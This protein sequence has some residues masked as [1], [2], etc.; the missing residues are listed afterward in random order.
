MKQNKIMKRSEVPEEFTWKLSDIFE[1]DEAWLEA[2]EE[3]KAYPK[4]YA[5]LQGKLGESAANLLKYFKLE[6]EVTLKL[7]AV[8]NY[9]SMKGDEDTSNSKYQDFRGKAMNIYMVISGASAFASPEIMA[10]PD[11]TLEGF[12]KEKKA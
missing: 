3:L 2:L 1:S 4:K 5:K 8:Y 9:A 6:D 11:E 10:I 7:E 12:Y